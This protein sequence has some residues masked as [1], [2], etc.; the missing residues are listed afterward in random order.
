MSWASWIGGV[1]FGLMLGLGLWVCYSLKRLVA[2]PCPPTTNSIDALLNDPSG[3]Y[4][5][6]FEDYQTSWWFDS[7]GRGTLTSGEG[8]YSYFLWKPES[9][10]CILI[11]FTHHTDPEEDDWPP[12]PNKL[13]WNETVEPVNFRFEIIREDERL[14]L[15]DL[16]TGQVF[17]AD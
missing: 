12:S 15:R 8:H 1:L 5:L 17:H 13:V 7:D 16:G 2:P 3:I 4:W 14:C 10:G 9:S 6:S 11:R